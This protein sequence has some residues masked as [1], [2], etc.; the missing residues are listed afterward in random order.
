M[1]NTEK[2]QKQIETFVNKQIKKTLVDQWIIESLHQ[3]IIK[4]INHK[5]INNLHTDT[6]TQR[7]TNV[8]MA[9]ALNTKISQSPSHSKEV[10]TIT[11]IPSMNM[12]AC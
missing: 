9:K 1:I 11:L 6:Q 3:S 5:I 8:Y 10:S 2:E 4:S 12:T 7:F